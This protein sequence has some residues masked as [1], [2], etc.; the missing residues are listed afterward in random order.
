ME[1]TINCFHILLCKVT[2]YCW[3]EDIVQNLDSAIC[4]RLIVASEVVGS[5]FVSISMVTICSSYLVRW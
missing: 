2:M 1:P 3:G 4:S 5:P